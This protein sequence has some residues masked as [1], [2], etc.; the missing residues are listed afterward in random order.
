MERRR[1]W[2]QNEYFISSFFEE[3]V[4][5][6]LGDAAHLAVFG[7]GAFGFLLG[8]PFADFLAFEC[9]LTLAPVAPDEAAEEALPCQLW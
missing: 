1:Q 9:G 6:A 3:A 5:F 2:R 4:F 7:L 8:A